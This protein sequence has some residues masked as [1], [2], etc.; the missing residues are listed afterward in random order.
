MM[1]GGKKRGRRGVNLGPGAAL[2]KKGELKVR[3]EP[4]VSG[5]EIRD[6]Y[7]PRSTKLGHQSGA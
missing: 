3:S 7:E 6:R 4:W 5:G 2:E 1:L